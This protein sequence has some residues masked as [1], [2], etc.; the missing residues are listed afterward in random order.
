MA[1]VFDNFRNTLGSGVAKLGSALHLPELGISEAISG[2]NGVKTIQG[3]ADPVRTPTYASVPD[4]AGQAQNDYAALLKQIRSLSAPA[5]QPVAPYFDIAANFSRARSQA[6]A[7]VNPLYTKKLNDFITQ[8]QTD[9][10]RKQADT[11]TANSNLDQALKDTLEASQVSR[12]RTAEDTTQKVG[13][14]NTAEQNFQSDNG[15]AFDNLRQTL[16]GNT[17]ASGLQ[18][19]GLGA[20]A[21]AAATASRNTQE[22]RAVDSFH[23]QKQAQETAKTRTFE[24]LLR[25]DNQNTVSTQKNKDQVKISLDRFIQDQGTQL[26]QTK[27]ELEARRLSDVINQEGSYAKLGFADFLKTLKNPQQIALASQTYGGIL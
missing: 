18:T 13:Q 26:A 1:S 16:A 21:V 15:T 14:L 25:S 10:A 27:D 7:A 8:Q 2:N 11:A 22:G 4:Y 6:E 24:D 5:P 9:A 17:A 20:K 19:S 23:V 12:D 3:S